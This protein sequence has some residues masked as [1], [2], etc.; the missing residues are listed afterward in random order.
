MEMYVDEELNERR[1]GG[2]LYDDD[3][4]AKDFIDTVREIELERSRVFKE[5]TIKRNLMRGR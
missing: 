2:D 3:D 5:M 4:N 1:N